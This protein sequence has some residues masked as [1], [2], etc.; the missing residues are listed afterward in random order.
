MKALVDSTR[1][2]DHDSFAAAN[3]A[4]GRRSSAG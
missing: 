2:Y 1:A 4:S 3:E